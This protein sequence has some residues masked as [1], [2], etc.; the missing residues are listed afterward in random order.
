MVNV[1]PRKKSTA[2]L[3]PDLKP[4]GNKMKRGSNNQ[5]SKKPQSRSTIQIV[6]YNCNRPG[7][8]AR[9]YRNW[10]HPT[11]QTNL[12]EEVLVAM[13]TE[14]NV[15]GGFEGWWLD[16]GA[17]RHVFH[18]LSLFTK[19]KETVDKNILLKNHDTTKVTDIGEVKLKFTFGKT[20]VLKEVLHTHE[21]RKN[22]VSEY[23]L[24]KA[25]FTQA[26]RSDIFTLTKNNVFMGKGYATNDMFKLNL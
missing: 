7:H 14:V 9:N 8:L 3:K 22:L 23:L 6:C 20:L 5:S 25:D 19:Y 21:I 1:V 16:T 15:I 13:I 18:D 12:V 11:V 24:N 17:S 10:I 26:I 2:I 4:K